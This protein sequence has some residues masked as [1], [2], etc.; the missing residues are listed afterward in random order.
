MENNPTLSINR[1]LSGPLTRF[2]TK[3][4]ITPNQI[5]LLGLI[6]GVLCGIFFAFGTYYS[7]V[8]AAC[9]FELAAVLDNCDGEVARI[10]NMKSELGGLLDIATDLVS[11]ISLFLGL[12]VGLVMTLKNPLL[13]IAGVL[14]CMGSLSNFMVV[15]FEKTKGFGPAVFGKP[16]PDHSLR[17]GAIHRL[18]DAVREGDASWFVLFFAVSGQT[19]YLLLLGAVYIH[20]LWLSAVIMNFKALTKNA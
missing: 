11:D 7:S 13:I 16:H 3:T 19:L 20:I 9:F 15:A 2:F 8:A 17:T 4:P 12:T 18:I 10:K 5:T 6:F 14:G 1:I